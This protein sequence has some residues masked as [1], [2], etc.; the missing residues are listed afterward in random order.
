MKIAVCIKAVPDPNKTSDIRFDPETKNV[1]RDNLE[2]VINPT[3]LH[4]I[5]LAVSLKE[6]HTAEVTVFSMG[7]PSTQKQL[8]EALSYGI[9]E[10]VLLSDRAFGGA[11]SLATSYTLAQ[12]IRTCGDYDLVIV[13]N[14]SS[15]GGTTN[16]PSQ[17]G[18]WIGIPHMMEVVKCDYSGGDRISV[19]KK[20]DD[21][22]M[23]F[24]VQLPAVIA[25]SK[26]INKVRYPNIK[27]IMTA[28]KKPLR[29]LDKTSLD[30]LNPDYIGAAGSPTRNGELKELSFSRE[31]EEFTGTPEEIAKSILAKIR[32]M[33]PSF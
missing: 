9:D 5:E 17:L 22:F 4:A 11:D 14:E 21:D 6:Q 18:E 3:D 26:V 29:I 1:I 16:V 31:C 19:R 7:P 12:S 30:L 13:G 20:M 2:M 15:D 32:P 8:R 27:G 25:V 33:V 28:K 10:A 24:D 23:D